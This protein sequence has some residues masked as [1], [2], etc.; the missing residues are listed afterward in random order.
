[1]KCKANAT[2]LPEKSSKQ[3]FGSFKNFIGSLKNINFM[4][5]KIIVTIENQV[6]IIINQI[7]I[8]TTRRFILRQKKVFKFIFCFSFL[9]P[10][11]D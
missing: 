3:K 10:F 6:N 7:I 11:E 2:K 1:M 8:T 9:F 5:L 4:L